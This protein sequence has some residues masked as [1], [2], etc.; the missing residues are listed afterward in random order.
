M[1]GDT[2]FPVMVLYIS[3]NQFELC[4][5]PRDIKTGVAFK[6]MNTIADIEC[7]KICQAHIAGQRDAG[8]KEPSWSN[9][10]SYYES[11]KNSP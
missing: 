1:L 11:T 10:Y 2:G 3:S 7:E 6:I 8:C 9:A 4:N 5:T